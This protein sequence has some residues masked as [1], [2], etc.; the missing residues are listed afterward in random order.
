MAARQ[1][2]L[3]ELSGK[4][5]L[6]W[7][8]TL[9]T[10]CEFGVREEYEDLSERGKKAML[11]ALA[12]SVMQTFAHET[13]PLLALH[14]KKTMRANR[15]LKCSM[16]DPLVEAMLQTVRDK[17][18]LSNLTD[19]FLDHVRFK[20]L[21]SWGVPT[22][23]DMLLL[24]HQG[25][26]AWHDRRAEMKGKVTNVSVQKSSSNSSWNGLKPMSIS[27]LKLFETMKGMRMECKVV[28]EPHH[29]VGITTVLQDAY[30]STVK[31][32]IYNLKGVVD[33][34]SAER[35]LP[36]GSTVIIAEPFLKIMMD[37]KRGVRV[38]NPNEIHIFL[39]GCRSLPP[40]G[41]I[42]AGKYQ[43][44]R[45]GERKPERQQTTAKGLLEDYKV[46]QH[47]RVSGLTSKKGLG[48]NGRLGII[49][50]QDENDLER[51]T[52]NIECD[53]GK[54]EAFKIQTCN[55]E[56]VAKTSLDDILETKTK[57][58]EAFSRGEVCVAVEG[59]DTVVRQ[60]S[61]HKTSKAIAELTKCLCNRA[62][63]FL[64]QKKWNSAKDDAKM[65]LEL[66]PANAKAHY[67]L[68]SAIF[69]EGEAASQEDMNLAAFH[70]SVAIALLPKAEPSMTD[71]LGAVAEKSAKP[72]FR[73]PELMSVSTS[74]GL[75]SALTMEQIKF[76]VTWL[77]RELVG[78]EDLATKYSD[79]MCFNAPTA[80]R[81]F[82]YEDQSAF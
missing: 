14:P 48:L 10:Y 52:V 63:C 29:T 17:T 55:L 20:L 6:C 70:I 5:R 66:E 24:E 56:I 62:L 46:G 16:E 15:S 30:G 3:E 54:A 35:V 61:S 49:T 25:L 64:K 4:G 76:I 32:G 42:D 47:V 80:E 9:R 1:I 78:M 11:T 44:A 34:Q 22:S 67:R 36:K 68:A 8:K 65:A 71:L 72:V 50:T 51:V 79:R 39:P 58:N 74:S 13:A 60:L 53:T 45:G 7:E 59:Y 26:D 69:Q 23:S 77:E 82:V 81:V 31:C 28:G 73:Q 33:R 21:R 2:S 19:E 38:D 75:S 18:V 41:S 27:E 57:A 12:S 40:A 43:A 37:G